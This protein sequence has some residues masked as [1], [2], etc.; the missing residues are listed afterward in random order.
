MK[1]I[2]SV[3]FFNFRTSGDN[4]TVNDRIFNT[5]GAF[6]VLWGKSHCICLV[7]SS[8]IFYHEI[9]ETLV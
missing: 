9:K 7:E 8:S 6:T 1:F 3:S 4:K 5:T 2:T